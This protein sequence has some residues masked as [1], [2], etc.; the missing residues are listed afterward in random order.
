M[1]RVGITQMLNEL[2]L[3]QR[4]RMCGRPSSVNLTRK[5][6]GSFRCGGKRIRRL[7]GGKQIFVHVGVQLVRIPKPMRCTYTPKA[8]E[9]DMAWF[10]MM[11]TKN[12]PKLNMGPCLNVQKGKCALT[13][14][15]VSFGRG[16]PIH[17]KVSVFRH[18]DCITCVLI[19]D[20]KIHPR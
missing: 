19:A 5:K 7:N 3:R 10:I 20:E 11:C 18:Q 4:R 13:S 8:R 12:I 9:Q 16:V 1:W 2:R 6:F 14:S 17:C 15:K